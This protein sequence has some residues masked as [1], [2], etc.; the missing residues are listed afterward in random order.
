MFERFAYYAGHAFVISVAIWFGLIG[1]LH[2]L[3]KFGFTPKFSPVILFLCTWGLITFVGFICGFETSKIMTMY[4]FVIF[5]AGALF[6]LVST[7]VEK[8]G[9]R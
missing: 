3:R 9:K 1:F 5:I 6:Y 2:A 7:L 8:I 4:S